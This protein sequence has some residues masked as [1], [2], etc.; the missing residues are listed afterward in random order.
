MKFNIQTMY[1]L[2]FIRTLLGSSKVT[3]VSDVA[4][5][6]DISVHMLEQIANKLRKKNLVKSI[7]GPNGG[8][9]VLGNPTVADV[10]RAM[11]KDTLLVHSKSVNKLDLETA[12]Y[13]NRLN[14][15][16]WTSMNVPIA[17]AIR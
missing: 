16:I 13:L 17:E 11:S 14:D 15:S 12:H 1:A 2:M 4:D 5:Y 10:V 9:T 3:R 8:Y 7:R 6:L